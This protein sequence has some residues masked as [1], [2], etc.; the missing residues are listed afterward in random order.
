MRQRCGGALLV[1]LLLAGATPFRVIPQEAPDSTAVP[2]GSADDEKGFEG[3]AALLAE[4]LRDQARRALGQGGGTVTAAV[5]RGTT[6]FTILALPEAWPRAAALVDSVVYEAPIDD[7]I[8]DGH[9]RGQLGR[10]AFESDSPGTEFEAEAARLLAPSGSPWARPVRGTTESIS[11]LS[12]AILDGFRRTFYHRSETAR[13]VVGPRSLLPSGPVA[14]RRS[15]DTTVADTIPPGAAA[16]SVAIRDTVPPPAEGLLPE[17][18]AGPDTTP[19]LA[20]TS[21]TRVDQIRDVTSTWIR[22]AYP[23]AGSTSRTAAEMVATLVHDELDPTPPDP[24]RYGVQV[25]L[26]DVP[27]GTALVVDVTVF[28]EA[29]ARWENK[30][31]GTVSRLASG[32]MQ[33]DLFGWRRRRF[34]TERLLEEAPPEVEAVRMTGDLMRT[35]RSRDLAVEIWSLDADAVYQAAKRLGPPRVLRFGPDLGQAHVPGTRDS[36][37][38][39]RPVPTGPRGYT[40]SGRNEVARPCSGS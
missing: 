22:I 26:V 37:G 33:P 25:R 12:P 27:G 29:A 18:A 40:L 31:T 20:W 3:T 13:A 35:G 4:I 28:P 6:T 34:R 10:L 39:S 32:P 30:I 19:S 7:S 23:V 24:D 5:N 1:G 9:K 2:V 16:D 38:T 21:G 17:S 8:L 36:R 15:A 14:P 11:A